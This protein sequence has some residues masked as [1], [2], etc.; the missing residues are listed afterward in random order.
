[1]DPALSQTPASPDA[2]N[3]DANPAQ[4]SSD[5]SSAPI[6]VTGEQ[7]QAVTMAKIDGSSYSP[8]ALPPS[9][10]SLCPS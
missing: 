1:M 8:S 6:G 3:V 7:G 4:A 5:L 9:L 2:A 10:S